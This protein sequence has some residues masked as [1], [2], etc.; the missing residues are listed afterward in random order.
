MFDKQTAPKELIKLCSLPL[1]FY[2]CFSH[3]SPL[4]RLPSLTS[5]CLALSLSRY[6]PTS[7]LRLARLP[8]V[9][10]LLHLPYQSQDVCFFPLHLSPPCLFIFKFFFSVLSVLSTSHPIS[11]L[12]GPTISDMPLI[13]RDECLFFFFFLRNEKN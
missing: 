3:N 2:S 13:R 9:S 12:F 6:H 10:P 1:L 11:L 7:A 5:F 4:Q 8:S